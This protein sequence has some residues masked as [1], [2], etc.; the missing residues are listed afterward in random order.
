[1]QRIRRTNRYQTDVTDEEW[2]VI[3]HHLPAANSI[4]RPHAWP[5]REIINGIF[6][7][8]RA[9]CPS[10][11]LPSD[12][13]PWNTVYGW[14]AK[15]RDEDRFE[16]INHA[17]VM[18]DRERIG[19]QVSPAGATTANRFCGSRVASSRSSRGS[20]PTAGIRARR[21]PKAP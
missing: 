11:L 9:G 21:S 7:V 17:L 20:S 5:M 13:P 19:R 12:L 14:F 18:L 10:R 4:G 16:K 15:F 8:M 2:R 3:E 6:H 1:M